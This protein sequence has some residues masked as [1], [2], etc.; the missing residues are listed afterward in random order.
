MPE[1]GYCFHF[2]LCYLTIVSCSVSLEDECD[3]QNMHHM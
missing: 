2:W 1:L 3:I